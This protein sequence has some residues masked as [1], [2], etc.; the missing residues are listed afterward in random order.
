MEKNTENKE[1]VV[2]ELA[3]HNTTQIQG[4]FLVNTSIIVNCSAFLVRGKK[5]GLWLFGLGKNRIQIYYILK[6]VDRFSPFLPLVH[7]T[8]I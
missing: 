7:D 4:P 8:R 3:L 2:S 5:L 6:S 1:T